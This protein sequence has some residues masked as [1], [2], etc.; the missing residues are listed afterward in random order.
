MPSFLAAVAGPV[1]V[2]RSSLLR[3][4]LRPN[5]LRPNEAQP[6][7]ADHGVDDEVALLGQQPVAALAHLLDL[8]VL[9]LYGCY[10]GLGSSITV[11]SRSAF[12]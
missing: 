7:E 8:I 9:D 12:A 5:A 3:P 4:A 2:V 6:L 11:L 10:E 1:A